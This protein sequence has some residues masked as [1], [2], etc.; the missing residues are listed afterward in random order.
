LVSSPC[1]PGRVRL[2]GMKYPMMPWP[3]LVSMPA[4]CSEKEQFHPPSR[5][6]PPLAV[7]WNLACRK[8][9]SS[10]YPDWGREIFPAGCSECLPPEETRGSWVEVVLEG[11]VRSCSGMG[12]SAGKVGVVERAWAFPLS[13]LA[14]GSGVWCR[15][16]LR[17]L[18]GVRDWSEFLGAG[19]CPRPDLADPATAEPVLFRL[20]P[21]ERVLSG[22]LPE[23]PGLESSL[24]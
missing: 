13:R 24:Y 15:I 6:S 1:N 9:H 3:D 10:G 4:S 18:S 22:F 19:D 23:L 8:R 20:A 14:Y 16:G 11:G 12:W 17:T 2:Q 21:E 5:L 7:S